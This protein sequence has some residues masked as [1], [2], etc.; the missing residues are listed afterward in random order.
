MVSTNLV[1]KQLCEIT[2]QEIPWFLALLGVEWYVV[3]LPFRF[4]QGLGNTR[5]RRAKQ[6]DRGGVRQYSGASSGCLHHGCPHHFHRI[7]NR[8][9]I[10]LLLHTMGPC[11]AAEKERSER[12]AA[13]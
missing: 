10:S 2:L 1:Q 9:H 7:P 11:K 12:Y 13:D 8:H 4:V 3:L 5:S 6:G